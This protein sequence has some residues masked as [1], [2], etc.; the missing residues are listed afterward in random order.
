MRPLDA[1]MLVACGCNGGFYYWGFILCA[2]LLGDVGGFKL[3]FTRIET[4]ES[5]PDVVWSCRGMHVEAWELVGL[6]EGFSGEER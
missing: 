4:G 2:F 5:G 1:K 6:R 3:F